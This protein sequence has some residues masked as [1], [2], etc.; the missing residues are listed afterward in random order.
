MTD[1]AAVDAAVAEVNKAYGTVDILI[2]NAG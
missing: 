2:N 1:K